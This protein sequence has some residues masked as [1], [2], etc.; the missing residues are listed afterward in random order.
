MK[1][2]LLDTNAISD[3]LDEAKPRHEAVSRRAM[4]VAQG[5]S[6]IVTSS[7]VL[8]EIEYGIQAAPQ[9]KQQALNALRR[10]VDVQ[11]VRKRLLFA[12][13]GATAEV[14]GKLRAELFEKF[15]DK[16]LKKTLRPEQLVDPLTSKALGIQENDLWIAAQAIE[17]N[18]ILVTNDA[19]LVRRIQ[20]V[21]SDLKVEDWAA[22]NS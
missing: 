13:D 3:W 17:R 18:L 11:F 14:Y 9:E 20:T 12:P 6:L 19:R 2:Y 10:Q 21:A 4:E 1:G 8:G 16:N 7:V 22:S 15:A 5:S